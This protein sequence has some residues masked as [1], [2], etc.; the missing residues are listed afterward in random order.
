LGLFG[1]W[2]F[3]ELKSDLL[4]NTLDNRQNCRHIHMLDVMAAPKKG[5]SLW[6]FLMAVLFFA[7][8]VTNFVGARGAKVHHT[9]VFYPDRLGGLGDTWMWL[10]QSYFLAALCLGLSVYSLIALLR[11]W[12]P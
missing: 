4:A 12:R 1:A 10:G 7:M 8:A 5:H 2:E 9:V 11:R 3:L 6:F